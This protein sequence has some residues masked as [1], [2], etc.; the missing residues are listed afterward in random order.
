[1]KSL[2][3]QAK[4]YQ[5]Q[6]A[7]KSDKASL[8]QDE[9]ITKLKTLED[10]IASQNQDVNSK[11]LIIKEAEDKIA[12]LTKQET[13]L[14]KEMAI[15]MDSMTEIKGETRSLA[16]QVKSLTEQA[17]NYQNQVAH[18]KDKAS[19]IQEEFTT[20]ISS[21]ESE[22]VYL[23]QDSEKGIGRVL[24]LQNQN[25]LL[26]ESNMKQKDVI[27]S[28]SM[29]IENNRETL[30]AKND[31]IAKLESD[32]F[33]QVGT[34]TKA[35]AE[36]KS[37]SEDI[38]SL[39]DQSQADQKNAASSALEYE[40][41]EHQYIKMVRSLEK[42]MS[43]KSGELELAQGEVESLS[44]ELRTLSETNNTYRMKC[45]RHVEK[46]AEQKHQFA[47]KVKMLENNVASLKQK[48]FVKARDM[49]ALR[50]KIETS[51]GTIVESKEE[52]EKSAR[53]L[54]TLRDEQNRANET[55]AQQ[56]DKIRILSVKLE[57][58]QEEIL[59]LNAE[60]DRLENKLSMQSDATSKSLNEKKSLKEQVKEL[61]DESNVNK[62]EADLKAKEAEQ[63]H[64]QYLSKIGT[65]VK[66]ISSQKQ[67][68]QT[69][70][71]RELEAKERNLKKAENKICA[72]KE[73]I[74]TSEAARKEV[75]LKLEELQKDANIMKNSMAKEGKRMKLLLSEIQ[76]KQTIITAKDAEIKS[77]GKNVATYIN[78]TSKIEKESESLEKEVIVLK[79]QV[80]ANKEEATRDADR[81]QQI[82]DQYV[83][84]IRTLEMAIETLQDKSKEFIEIRSEQS[85]QIK[86]LKEEIA[87]QKEATES[88]SNAI[89]QSQKIQEEYVEKIKRL[90][91]TQKKKAESNSQEM[92]VLEKKLEGSGNL[93]GSFK[94]AIEKAELESEE[95]NKKILK[96]QVQ[97]DNAK[98]YT[99]RQEDSIKY[100]SRE[101][102]VGCKLAT[103][104]DETIKKIQNENKILTVEL[105]AKSDTLATREVE[106]KSL[107]GLQADALIGQ[108][109]AK[110]EADHDA[111]QFQRIED[112]YVTKIRMLEEDLSSTKDLI[113]LYKVTAVI[114][115]AKSNQEE[116]NHNIQQFKR[117]EDENTTKIKILERDLRSHR[118][119]IESQSRDLEITRDNLSKADELVIETRRIER[120][121]AVTEIQ[122]FETEVASLQKKMK[123][124]AS[125]ANSDKTSL[126][127]KI[128][129]LEQEAQFRV[130]RVENP[131][132]LT[133][134]RNELIETQMKYRDI[135]AEKLRIGDSEKEARARL[136]ELM[137]DARDNEV[138]KKR[139][140][141][142]LIEY[143][144]SSTRTRDVNA[145]VERYKK[146]RESLRSLAVLGLKKITSMATFGVLGGQKGKKIRKTD[147]LTRT[148]RITSSKKIPSNARTFRRP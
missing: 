14:R 3:E 56:E 34:L 94:K 100:L 81:A 35:Q 132:E 105:S 21:L 19:K 80:Q 112:Q 136:R 55:Y 5:N 29:K 51:E 69:S 108:V 93:I 120:A 65:L 87:L 44:V 11:S 57:E 82:E 98:E 41:M 12:K 22:I 23:K 102:E 116:V 52:K 103:A 119:T 25:D 38:E 9:Y 99:A 145:D 128:I 45:D 54:L 114:D 1:V 147:K 74:K 75:M 18:K 59:G 72:L 115:Q 32:L 48:I 139:L 7:R 138:E 129:Y 20:E 31:I 110:K 118:D 79:E 90:I 135:M 126:E 97:R 40:E 84:K 148:R 85:I 96:L 131:H 76:E 88:R 140:Q 127:T 4:N 66:E 62:E 68:M 143:K 27:S 109:K 15:S 78:S 71:F 106:V 124:F 123:D 73:S 141:K 122:A 42:G 95:A 125:Q 24:T 60:V 46:Y 53:E 70:N 13:D 142:D 63:K 10:Q 117:M 58:R 113:L 111:V 130:S 104:R 26:N 144:E 39:L 67:I 6:V 28:L 107:V 17:K 83:T 36:I 89:E 47:K 50:R 8:M 121:Q 133:N 92:A 37:L 91:S 86:V 43:R 61:V 134:L 64:T 2:T 77:L 49:N 101:I 30:G 16:E 146:E 137:E 33:T